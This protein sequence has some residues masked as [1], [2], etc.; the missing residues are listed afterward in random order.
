FVFQVVAGRYQ[1]ALPWPATFVLLGALLIS[2]RTISALAME[3]LSG[4]AI[5]EIRLHLARE[6][7]STPLDHLEGV[8]E[9]RLLTGLTKEVAAVSIEIPTLVNLCSS[10]AMVFA[11][12]LYI[13][14]LSPIGALFVAIAVFV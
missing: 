10:A 6:I 2:S 7:L 13:A 9:T 5:A 11:L 1:A 8:G 12:M 3:R 4:T 14:W